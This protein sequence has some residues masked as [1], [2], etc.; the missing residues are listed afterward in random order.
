MSGARP[1]L[2]TLALASLA[3]CMSPVNDD[4]RDALGGEAPG[5]PANEYHRPGQPCLVCHGEYGGT[6]PIMAVAGTVF[7]TPTPNPVPV[8]K[9]LVTLTDSNGT[10]V[11]KET[12]CVGNFFFTDDEWTPAFPLRAEISCP[13][14]GSTERRR[15]VMGT[16]IG[17]DGSCGGCHQGAPGLDS[18]GWVYCAET[19]P[20]PPYVVSPGCPGVP[21]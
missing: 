5:V 14:P 13:R 18:P 3:G 7:A 15:F 21:H 20:D 2:F 16:R 4:A 6:G 9:A 17:R 8:E 1:V 12:N 19:M 11:S 10:T